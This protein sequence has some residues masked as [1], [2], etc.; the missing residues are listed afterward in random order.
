MSHGD[1]NTKFF[2]AIA[3]TRR[4]TNFIKGLLNSIGDWITDDQSLA[5]TT[6]DYFDKMFTS[7]N[8]SGQ[9]VTKATMSTDLVVDNHMNDFLCAPFT[10]DEV[11][12]AIFDMHLSKS[13]GPDGFTALFFKKLW[14]MIG[15]D[16]R[17][18]VLSIMNDNAEISQ[19][20]STLITLIPKLKDPLSLKDYRP[21]NPYN[22]S[23]KIVSRA[24]TNRFRP[25]LE[26][27]ID[28]F[29]SAFMRGRLILDNVI[30]GFEC[31]HWIRE[32][33]K[34]RKQNHGLQH[35]T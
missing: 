9:D 4:H 2:H 27:V 29:Q 30:F 31:M 25:V 10:I 16:V 1:R 3:S 24:I 32:R 15:K 21:I 35:L 28:D 5:Q 17:D 33:K 22:T 18:P 14:P 12:K 6:M 34:K 23:Y 13:P 8:P 26:N 19:W 20:N 11:H 7:S